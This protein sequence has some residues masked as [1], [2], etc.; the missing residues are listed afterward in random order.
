MYNSN[1]KLITISLGFVSVFLIKGEGAVLI[2]VGP[3]GSEEK[4]IKKLNESGVKPDEIKLILLTHAH[5][6]HFGSAQAMRKLT[7]AKI[8][9]HKADAENLRKGINGEI[10]PTGFFGKMAGLFSKRE[11][12]IGNIEPDIT[13][14]EE[15]DL[16]EYGVKGRVLL[17]PGHT[18]GSISVMLDNNEV[19]VGDLMMGLMLKKKPNY[20]IVAD[21]MTQLKESIIKVVKTN[22]KKIYT[23][24]GKSFQKEDVV[25]TFKQIDFS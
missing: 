17:T 4:I 11:K 25:K 10:K 14:E 12:S 2:D 21:D 15:F 5:T 7:G 1:G 19:I 6:D 20:P 8:A 9:I 23:S 18:P 16:G 22:P 3:Q 13:F 24:H